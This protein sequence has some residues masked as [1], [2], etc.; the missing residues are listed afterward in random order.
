MAAQHLPAGRNALTQLN[1]LHCSKNFG[2]N[3]RKY[4]GIQPR[5]RPFAEI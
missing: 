1:L 4:V 3:P 2:R 5:T